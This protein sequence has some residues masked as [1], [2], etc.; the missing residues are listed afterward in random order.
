MLAIVLLTD[1]VSS[2]EQAAQLDD[3]RQRKLTVRPARGSLKS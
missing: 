1:T 2:T 3:R